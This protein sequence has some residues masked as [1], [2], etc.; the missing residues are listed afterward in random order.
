[1]LIYDSKVAPLG[2]RTSAHGI[3]TSTVAWLSTLLVKAATWLR[4]NLKAVV[5][6]T[7]GLLLAAER[8]CLMSKKPNHD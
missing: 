5:M 3:I 1:M 7:G 4:E 2:F 8:N 6:G